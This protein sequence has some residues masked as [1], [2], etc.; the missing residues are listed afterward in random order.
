MCK[1]CT[2]LSADDRTEE[3]G[4]W[5]NEINAL[6]SKRAQE[7]INLLAERVIRNFRETRRNPQSSQQHLGTANDQRLTNHE[8]VSMQQINKVNFKRFDFIRVHFQAKAPEG[9]VLDD[10]LC[11]EFWEPAFPELTAGDVIEVTANDLSWFCELI[12]L[13][14]VKDNASRFKAKILRHVALT[15]AAGA[16]IDLRDYRLEERSGL[17]S[18][19]PLVAGSFGAEAFVSGLPNEEAARQWVRQE[20]RKE[21]A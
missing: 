16:T 11:G 14:V 13:R 2:H 15:D 20:L 5:R 9:A 12:V 17:W 8:R 19:F 7:E 18:V 4:L 21:T 3:I 6:A 1:F 10:L